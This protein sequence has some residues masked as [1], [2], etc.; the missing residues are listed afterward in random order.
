[1]AIRKTD[2]VVLAG[3]LLL[4]SCL[5]ALSTSTNAQK[6]RT[7]GGAPRATQS[8][9]EFKTC[10]VCNGS[11]KTHEHVDK[12]EEVRCN[13][14]AGKGETLCENTAGWPHRDEYWDGRRF[15]CPKCNGNGRVR[16]PVCY[17]SGVRSVD[18]G[19][20]VTKVC[21]NCKGSGRVALT[22]EEIRALLEIERELVLIKSGA[23]QMGDGD[24]INTVPVHRVD[25]EKP[26]YMGKYEV[27]QAQWRA[28]MGSNPSQ[29]KGDDLPVENVSWNDAKEFCRKLSQMTGREYR[30]PTEAE[31]EYACRAGTTGAYAGDLDAMAWYDKNSGGKTHP[32]GQKQPNAFGLYDMHGNVWEW[33]EDDWHNSYNGA[34]NDGRAWVD[35]SARGSYRVAR[36]GSWGSNAVRSRSAYRPGNT[37]G[38][39]VNYLGFRLLR[40]YR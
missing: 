35:I 24:P 25:I 37:P 19:Y 9:T 23:F 20:E 17:G 26:F 30:L 29:F 31:W 14:C 33:C 18:R 39:R 8:P 7:G 38:A 28:V 27:T 15:I 4:L 10:P 16:C 32:V 21:Y 40:T 22:R 34:P 2:L 36:G 6:R 3:F 11:G 5:L 13:N 1:M 12:Y